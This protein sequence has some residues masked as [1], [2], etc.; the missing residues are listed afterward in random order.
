MEEPLFE[1]IN[2]I[3][4]LGEYLARRNEVFTIN[5][6]I[7][8]VDAEAA[9]YDEALSLEEIEVCDLLECRYYGELGSIKR[10]IECINEVNWEELKKEIMPIISKKPVLSEENK[11]VYNTVKG[12]IKN[13]LNK[14]VLQLYCGLRVIPIEEQLLFV[15]SFNEAENTDEIEDEQYEYEENKETPYLIYNATQKKFYLMQEGEVLVENVREDFAMEI[16][17]DYLYSEEKKKALKELQS[18]KTQKSK[19]EYDGMHIWKD[20]DIGEK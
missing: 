11:K 12:R 8:S 14:I 4:I 1:Y 17:I 3:K 9:L 20:N 2:K 18:G 10:I 19:L 5:N 13:I 6:T 7:I 16:T 15:E